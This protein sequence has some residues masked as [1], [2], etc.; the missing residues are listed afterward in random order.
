MVFNSVTPNLMVESVDDAVDWY[1][2][3]F[4]AEVLGRMPESGEAVW[5]QVEVGESWLMFQGRE[6]LEEEFRA[7]EGASI[8]GSFS[9]YVDVDDA[10]D[11]HDELLEKGVEVELGLRDTDYGRREFAVR[12]PNGY[13]L[14]FGEKLQG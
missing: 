10:R 7:F 13:V 9:L 11:L 3:V 2:R 1:R 8:G 14:W 5:A 12:D 6:S 4:G